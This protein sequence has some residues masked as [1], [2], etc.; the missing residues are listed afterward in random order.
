MEGE[1]VQEVQARYREY[2]VEQASARRKK[3]QSALWHVEK[4]V[5]CME[6]L[7]RETGDEQV[8][9][10]KNLLQRAQDEITNR[11]SVDRA[12]TLNEVALLP[13]LPV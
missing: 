10:L 7:D 9:Y 6:Q 2:L 3:Y 13:V 4:A 11:M 5:T 12:E 1:S 8:I